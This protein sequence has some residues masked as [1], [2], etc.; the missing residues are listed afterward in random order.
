MTFGLSVQGTAKDM[1]PIIRD[2]VYRIGYEAIRNACLHSGAS[3]LEVELSYAQDLVLRVLDN[4]KGIGADA[5]AAA[6]KDGHFGLKGMQ[7]RATRV[8]GRLFLSSSA[9]KGTRVELIVPG[10][11]AFR[12]PNPVRRWPKQRD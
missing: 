1:H 2:E 5:A 11:V 6:G 10:A 9:G 8:R 7:E 12:D 4:G 3:R